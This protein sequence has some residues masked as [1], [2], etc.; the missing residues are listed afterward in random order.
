MTPLFSAVIPCYNHGSYLK[1]S[2]GSIEKINNIPIEIIIVDD[3]STDDATQKELALLKQQGYNIISQPNAG[4]GSARNNGISHAKGKYIIPLDADDLIRSEYVQKAYEVFESKEN[5]H[6][7][8]ADFQRFGDLDT[9]VKYEPFCIQDLI[10]KNSIGACAIFRK[11]VWEHVGGYDETLKLGYSW[12]DWDFW[13]KLAYNKFNFLYL[14]MIGYDYCYSTSSRERTFLKNKN[15]VNETITLFERKYSEMY[16]PSA[17]HNHLLFQ[18]KQNP[19][20][21]IGKILLALYFPK[22]YQKTVRKGKI[23]KYLF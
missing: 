12:E 16:K 20:G 11:E 10:I 5:I 22:W 15:R 21:M 14:D 19:V 3:G 13:L 23:R 8:Y 2:I 1:K 4:P 6:V 18:V 9:I 7:V 17:V